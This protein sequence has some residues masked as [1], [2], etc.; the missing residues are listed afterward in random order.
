MSE[1]RVGVIGKILQGE[2]KGF[3]VKVID[4]SDSTG[5]Y[6]ILTSE[7]KSFGSGFD[8]WVKNREDLEGYFREAGWK[9]DWLLMQ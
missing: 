3:F 9:I 5:G 4:D 2:E 6:L 7:E 1:I 8:G